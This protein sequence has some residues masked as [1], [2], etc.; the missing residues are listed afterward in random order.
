M[1]NKLRGVNLGGWLIP[2]KWITPGLFKGT[3]ARDLYQLSSSQLGR[4][5]LAK[6]FSNFITEADFK[7]LAE[8]GVNAIRLPVGYWS[9][10]GDSPYSKVI[11]H[12][13]WALAMAQKYNLKVLLDFHG[14]RGSQNGNDHSGRI[15]PAD[16]YE[17]RRYRQETLADL[18]ALANRYKDHPALWGLEILNEPKIGLFQLKLRR[19]YRQAYHR[20]DEILKPETVI[21][22]HDAFTA[23]L[24]S[25]VLP[26]AGRPVAMDIHW[27]HSIIFAAN[28]LPLSQYFKL[29]RRR[30]AKIR[31]LQRRQMVI[32]GEWSYVLSAEKLKA[33][34]K[35]EKTALTAQNIN[36][37]LQIYS[38]ADG[39]FY[40]TY[41]TEQAGQWSFRYQIEQGRI[42][43]N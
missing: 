7:W 26:R 14:A 15:G 8:N 6:H 9:M 37:Q 23:N 10:A 32:I 35:L 5:R 11:E 39:W 36:L 16:W 12:I 27:Y 30:L 2:E 18:A 3:E 33:K 19:F 1:D 13:D 24:M 22:F 41:K 29:L 28:K 42:K 40:W 21:V 43:L 31:R 38:Q 20:L 25:G 34:T 4:E 17:Q